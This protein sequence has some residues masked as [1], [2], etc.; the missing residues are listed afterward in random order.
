MCQ[1]RFSV[2]LFAV[3]LIAVPVCAVQLLLFA[4]EWGAHCVPGT[5]KTETLSPESDGWG[6]VTLSSGTTI[7]ATIDTW[8]PVVVTYGD[9]W[10]EVSSCDPPNWTCTE[11]EDRESKIITRKTNISRIIFSHEDQNGNAVYKP[12]GYEL[13]PPPTADGTYKGCY[14]DYGG[15]Y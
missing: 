10:C 11:V 14:D 12:G 8:T 13:S 5:V 2:T 4:Q 7:P 1:R 6:T 15:S 3:V 9:G